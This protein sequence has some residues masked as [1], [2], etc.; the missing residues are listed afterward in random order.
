MSNYFVL[1]IETCPINTD[2]YFA[3]KEEERLKKLNPI[4]SKIIAIGMRYNN[5]NLILQSDNEKQMLIDFWKKWLELKNQN[6]KLSVVGFNISNFDMSF[7]TT[8]SFIHNVKI[9]PFVVKEIIDIKERISAFRT[10]HTRGRLKEF[11][12]IIGLECQNYEGDKIPEMCK[13]GNFEEIKKYLEKD[14]EITDALY[15]RL[16]E[17]NIIDIARW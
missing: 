6:P 12:K 5:E 13:L 17:T 4:D 11:A 8:R 1:D 3:L 15:K 10:G 14:L 9:V 7:L 2:E 16:I